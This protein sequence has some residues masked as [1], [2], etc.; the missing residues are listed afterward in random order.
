MIDFMTRMRYMWK[1]FRLGYKVVVDLLGFESDD[2]VICET[3]SRK[4]FWEILTHTA[5]V[6]FE[7][8]IISQKARRIIVTAWLH[9]W[10]LRDPQQ[11]DE[12]V[13]DEA[14]A[15][16]LPQQEQEILEEGV[17]KG[18][19]SLADLTDY[20]ESVAGDCQVVFVHL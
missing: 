17:R 5:K 15:L 8:K 10:K 12:T 20:H 7:R 9:M 11:Y 18:K 4:E 13:N 3:C 2:G 19:E 6:A 14:K 1:K 16:V